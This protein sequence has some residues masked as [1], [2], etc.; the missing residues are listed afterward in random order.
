MQAALC[1]YKK[2]GEME[3]KYE[4]DKKKRT[5]AQSPYSENGIKAMQ[6]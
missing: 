6:T 1:A 5:L 4:W 2:N 3:K